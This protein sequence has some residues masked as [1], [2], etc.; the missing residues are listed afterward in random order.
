MTDPTPGT[1]AW[2]A[3]V[4][5]EIIE[6]ERPIVDPHHHLWDRPGGSYILEDLWGDT[7][8]GHNIEKT[9]FIECHANYHTD[10][11]E[12]LQPVGETEFV[13]SIAA[14]S[15]EGGEGR[16][17]IAAIVSHADLALGDRL[18]EV[19][20]AHKE[21]GKGLFR[22]IRHAGAREEASDALMIPGR[23]PK[24]LYSQEDFRQGV[25]VL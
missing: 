19:L 15:A 1:P 6:P 9:V 12:H 10:G 21:A 23:A 7:G 11:P 5:E 13:A 16:A 14:Q 18:E 4:E 2:L 24:D 17:R 22:G 25:K 8:S 20:G 3:Q